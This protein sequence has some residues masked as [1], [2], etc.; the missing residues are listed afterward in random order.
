[1]SDALMASFI[2]DKNKINLK[3]KIGNDTQKL[4]DIFYNDKKNRG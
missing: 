2:K 1:M 3:N 4:Y